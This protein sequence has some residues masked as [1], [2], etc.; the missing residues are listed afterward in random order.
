MEALMPWRQSRNFFK[1]WGQTDMC[2]Y[3]MIM[4]AKQ[5][6]L[7]IIY[8]RRHF[9]CARTAFDPRLSDL[10]ECLNFRS[11]YREM[12]CLDLRGIF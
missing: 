2:V 3:I 6:F 9:S 10:T 5:S 7:F 4:G 12:Q 1:C 8:I 11:V